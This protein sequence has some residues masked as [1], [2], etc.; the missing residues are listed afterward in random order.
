MRVVKV[1]RVKSSKSSKSSS[2]TELETLSQ[3]KSFFVRP[4]IL[5]LLVKSDETFYGGKN[6]QPVTK[7]QKQLYKLPLLY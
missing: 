5:L 1:V 4:E 2:K 7:I 3:K 6:L